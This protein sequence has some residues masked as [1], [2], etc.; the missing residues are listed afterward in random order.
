MECDINNPPF[1]YEVNE[2]FIYIN[3]LYHLEFLYFHTMIHY[4]TLHYITLQ[5][6]NRP[7][8]SGSPTENSTVL[9]FLLFFFSSYSLHNP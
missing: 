2:I 1:F 4:I 6:Y 9:L 3:Q 8:H 7:K 5:Y